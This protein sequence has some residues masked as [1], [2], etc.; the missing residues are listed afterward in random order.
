MD[1]DAAQSAA[2]FFCAAEG[3]LICR[4]CAASRHYRD[5]DCVPFADGVEARV[6][7]LRD[8]SDRCRQVTGELKGLALKYRECERLDTG[9]H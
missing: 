4:Q 2:E 1:T 3:R 6:R 9:L 5:R 7:E 8:E